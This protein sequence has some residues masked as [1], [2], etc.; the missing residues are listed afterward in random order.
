MSAPVLRKRG[1]LERDEETLIAKRDESAATDLRSG[2]VLKKR[3][4]RRCTG[5]VCRFNGLRSITDTENENC[6]YYKRK[7]ATCACQLNIEWR[8]L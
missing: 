1:A 3:T 5:L 2:C 8:N 7:A 4:R 6:L